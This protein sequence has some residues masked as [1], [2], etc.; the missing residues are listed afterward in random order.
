MTIRVAVVGHLEWIEFGRMEHVPA[1]G[2]IVHATERWEGARRRRRRY[3]S[4][5]GVSSAPMAW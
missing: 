2:E 1:A 3:P 5:P 4:T